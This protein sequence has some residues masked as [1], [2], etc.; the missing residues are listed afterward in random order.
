MRLGWSHE[1]I[2]N[3]CKIDPWFLEQMRGIV[4]MEA[5][6]REHGLPPN[7]GMRTLKAMG[8][9]DARLAVLA[10]ARPRPKSPPSATQLDVRPVFKRIDT[11]AA[12]FASPTAYMYSTYEA[13]FA[14][15]LADEAQPS[16]AQE[17][18]HPRRRA[19]PHRPGHRVRLLLLPCRL[20]AARRRLRNDHD[21]LQSGDGVDRLRH[22][23]PALFRAA[24]GRG[25]AGDPA[26][27]SA[28]NGT[29][30][31]RHRAVRRPDAAEARRRAGR[32]RHPDP[33]HLA[34]HD[35]PRR[36]PR[37]LQDAA[38]QARPHAAEERHRLFGRAGAPRRRPSSASR[39]WCARP[40]CSAAAPC[41]S[42]ARRSSCRRLPARHLPE[43]GAGGHQARYPN[44]KTGQINTVLGKN[45]LL[46][47][48]Y[49]S[50]AIEVDVDCLCDGKDTFIV[51]IMEHIEEAGI[52]SGDTACSLPPHSLRCRDDRRAGAADARARARRS[53][54]AA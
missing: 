15:A 26:R 8:F 38:R 13:P 12:E 49:L 42:S 39:W 20:R 41:R 4:D 32:G 31:R 37:P 23:G 9:S 35:R 27:P 45:P 29:L 1:E 6:V 24:D 3:S 28:S 22:L 53:T 50:D 51:G 44:D 46:F 34:R 36:G 47:D 40:M 25:R 21:Q 5:K 33:R 43:P 54:S 18:R 16:D 48:R 2:F 14:G 17:G 11:C 52:H 30:H 10:G 7:A 19:E